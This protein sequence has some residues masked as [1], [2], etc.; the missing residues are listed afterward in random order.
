[1]PV[2]KIVYGGNTLIDLS[3]DT[4]APEGLL[5]GI[6]AHDRSGAIIT[7]TLVAGQPNC[8]CCEINVTSAIGGSTGSHIIPAP[9]MMTEWLA[10]HYNSAGITVSFSS[11]FQIMKENSVFASWATDHYV[12]GVTTYGL[13]AYNGTSTSTIGNVTI[14]TQSDSVKSD[15]RSNFAIRL[16]SDGI[17]SIWFNS[18]TYR[19]RAGRYILTAWYY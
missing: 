17:V 16:N 1:M 7:G 18:T 9:T 5:T 12:L 15:C 14:R 13:A 10:A 4:V 3:N 6:T 11:A 8:R 2:N 19:I